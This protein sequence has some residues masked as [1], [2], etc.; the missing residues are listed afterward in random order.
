VTVVAQNQSAIGPVFEGIEPRLLLSAGALGDG[1]SPAFPVAGQQAIEALGGDLAVVARNYDLAADDLTAMLMLDPSLYIDPAGAIFYAEP[2]PSA[3]D[4]PKADPLTAEPAPAD[5]ATPQAAPYPYEWTFTLHSQVG[6][7]KVIYLDFDGHVT[8]AGTAWNGGLEIIST[9]FDRD[10]DPTTFSESEQALIQRIWQRVAEDYSPFN[11]DVTTEDPGREGLDRTN[12]RDRNYGIR[13]VITQD[14]SWYGGAGGVAYVGI[15]DQVG[16]FNKPAFIFSNN[17]RSEKY[18][19]EAASHEIGHTLGLHHDG[20]TGGSEYY[21]GHG[22]G[23]TTWASIMGMSY[24]KIVTQWSKGE[25]YNASNTEDDLA[26]ITSNG[27]GYR[28]DDHGDMVSSATAVASPAVLANVAKGII[29]QAGDVD[30]FRFSTTG[31]EVSLHVIAMAEGPNLD[32]LATVYDSDGEVIAIEDP[33]STYMARLSLTLES[34]TYYLA[35]TGTGFGTPLADPPSGYTSYGS[36]GQYWVRIADPND[37]PTDITLGG[38][39]VVEN[40]ANDTVVATIGGTDPEGDTLTFTLTDDAGGR[41]ALVGDV[42][43]VARGDLLNFESAATHS[44]TIRA[45]DGQLDISDT[46]IVTVTDVNEA[47]TDLALAGDSVAEHAPDA[48]VVGLVSATDPDGFALTFS[49]TDSAAG[50]FAL[51]GSTLVV[52]NG[53]L[54]DHDTAAGHDVTIEVADGEFTYSETFTINV[55]AGSSAPG[56]PNLLEA[57][58]S[59]FVN[60]DDLTNHDNSDTSSALQFA[61]G[62]TTPGSLVTLYANGTL[63]GSATAG[64]TTAVVTTDGAFDLADGS[65][66]VTA[67]QVEPGKGE[68]PH[69]AALTVTVDTSGPTVSA[70][71][72]TSSHATWTLGTLHSSVWTSGDDD[73]TAP[74]SRI[75]RL[76]VSFDE[77][78]YADADDLVL[79][80]VDGSV[81]G[82]E[83]IMGSG[84]DEVICIVAPPGGQL[85]TDQYALTVSA[86]VIDVAGNAL[87]D[88][89]NFTLTVLVGDINGDGRVSV[90]DRGELR[91]TYGSATGD[92]TYNIFADLNGDG[93]ISSR[94][95]RILRNMYGTDLPEAPPVS[96]AG[97][98]TST[99]LAPVPIALITSAMPTAP[100]KPADRTAEPLQLPHAAQTPLAAGPIVAAPAPTS[101]P[102]SPRTTVDDDASAPTQLRRTTVDDDASAP[103]QLRTALEPAL[104]DPLAGSRAD[105]LLNA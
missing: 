63:I 46:F 82:P 28:C 10:G 95:R 15:Y 54:L 68:S 76:I 13:C 32:I 67:R 74:W 84:S 58:D 33:A 8:A 94:D 30:M 12:H 98:T 88:G 11:V 29:E 83:S 43:Q 1:A 55:L 70:L 103:T 90:R 23:L 42:L 5:G 61:V 31:G 7:S 75:N 14:S 102:T 53:D 59:G 92:G 78:V 17:L 4:Q 71:G 47:P 49:L 77:L 16:G 80:G 96:P 39:A 37:A 24:Y 25:Y 73:Q 64:G 69:S 87:A 48:T 38:S 100:T 93:R 9:P 34:G 57:A 105:D 99:D 65:H 72:L 50:R 79:G 97:E 51:D 62:G 18:I 35:V 86:D 27:F 3:F 45:S 101:Q 44:V 21:G 66:A 26:I 85:D 104:D 81:V 89:W 52:A 41:F 40:A 19:A 36:L 22:S 2:A 56:A 91:N 20:L 60:D 6:A